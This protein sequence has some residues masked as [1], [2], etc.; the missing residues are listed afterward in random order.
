M[1]GENYWNMIRPQCGNC[2]RNNMV[3]AMEEMGSSFTANPNGNMSSDMTYRPV[4]PNGDVDPGMTLRPVNP[5]GNIDSS[6]T[7]RPVNPGGNIDSSMTIRPVNPG[8]NVDPGMTIRPPFPGGN[9]ETTIVTR[10][11]RPGGSGTIQRPIN[12]AP[13][14]LKSCMN[15]LVYVWLKNGEEFWMIPTASDDTNFRGYRWVQF[16]GWQNYSGKLS[17][18]SSVTCV[19]SM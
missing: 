14:V 17:D 1:S 4:T 10:P 11:S 3:A 6:M 19:F 12:T 15:G 13:A 9:I 2:S 5:G 8:G 16:I 18:I 7:V